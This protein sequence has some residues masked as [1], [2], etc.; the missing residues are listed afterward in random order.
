MP[1]QPNGTPLLGLKGGSDLAATACVNGEHA[2]LVMALDFREAGGGEV[3]E[4]L[5]E[6]AVLIVRIVSGLLGHAH[7]AVAKTQQLAAPDDPF[8]PYVVVPF[9]ER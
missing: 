6:R 4:L 3:R 1:V 7:E 2:V 8:P 9:S 5:A